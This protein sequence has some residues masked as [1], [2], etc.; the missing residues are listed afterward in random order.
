[1]RPASSPFGRG[2]C[3]KKIRKVKLGSFSVRETPMN[4]LGRADLINEALRILLVLGAG[5][6]PDSEDTQRVDARID[7]LFAELSVRDI[8]T[9]ADDEDIEPAYF[10]ALAELLASE[11]A[12]TFGQSRD[13]DA[14]SAAEERLKAMVRATPLRLLET[15]KVLR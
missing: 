2:S 3:G 7:P 8:V 6:S 1:M 13:A 4:Q 9:V 11:C 15:E 14:K 10:S 5:Q 12:P